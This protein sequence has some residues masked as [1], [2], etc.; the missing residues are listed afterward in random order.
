MNAQKFDINYLKT[1]DESELYRLERE[2]ARKYMGGLSWFMVLWPLLNVLCWFSIWP[3]VIYDVIPLWA[4]FIIAVI[5]CTLAY[6]PSHEAQHDIYARKGEKLYWLNQLIGHASL[7][8]LASS[9]RVLRETHI[10]HHKHTNNPDLDPDFSSNAE[11]GWGNI[12]NSINNFQ[13]GS[14]SNKA[15]LNT[16]ERLNTPEAKLA[17]RDQIMITLAFNLFLF[18]MAFSGYALEALLLWWLPIKLGFIYLRYYLS[19]R[20]HFPNPTMGRYQNTRAFKSWLGNLSSL[21]MTAHIVHH[22]HPRIPLDRTPAALRELEPILTLRGCSL[23]DHYHID[24]GFKK[25]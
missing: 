5:N 12:M 2:I 21:G 10:E 3:L 9:Y 8:P 14:K 23:E 4:G 17:I 16:L 15:Y 11:T 22:L 6:L 13:P 7:I 25:Q 20:P 1:L 18:I 19:W 24:A